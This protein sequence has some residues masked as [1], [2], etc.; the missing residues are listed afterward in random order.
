MP[1]GGEEGNESHEGAP[2]GLMYSAQLQIHSSMH[3]V[4]ELLAFHIFI[5]TH[6]QKKNGHTYW[7]HLAATQDII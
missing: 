3:D 2:M 5:I 1:C 4:W 7:L 6:Q